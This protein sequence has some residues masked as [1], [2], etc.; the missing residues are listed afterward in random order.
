MFIN[1]VSTVVSF[2][3]MHHQDQGG[4][5]RKGHG[6]H[7]WIDLPEANTS[8]KDATTIIDSQ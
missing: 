7:G 2:A 5:G 6:Q 1:G 8:R 4:S 3:T